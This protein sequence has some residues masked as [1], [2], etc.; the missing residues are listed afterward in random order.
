M[1]TVAI[2]GAGDLG[3]ATAQALL[4]RDRVNRIILID[5]SREAASG[6]A[7][8]MQQAGAVSLSHT[9]LEGTEDISRVAG[10]HICVMADRFGAAGEWRGEEGLAM[11]TRVASFASTAPIVFAGST[12]AD[13]VSRAVS[14][15]RVP[16]PRVL[17]SAP[18]AL[19]SAIAAIVAMEASCSP[20]QVLLT[21][22]GVPGA[23]VVPWSEASIGG[24]ALD[25]VLSQVQRSRIEAR[26]ARLWPPGPYALGAA[27]ARVVEASL[28]SS[29][30]TFSVLTVLGGEFGVRNRTG[31]LPAVL[32]PRGIVHKRTPEL[33]PRERVQVET[34]LGG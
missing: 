27:A 33:T 16:S 8:D 23:F 34:A 20:S 4:R 14:E 25:S 18:E 29:R 17:G 5:A 26:A 15:L 10:C 28:S 22:L 32:S 31:A 7:L 2:V 3:A 11:L 30:Q 13:L 1:T 24:Y 12:Q 21:V 6:K 9:R 19:I